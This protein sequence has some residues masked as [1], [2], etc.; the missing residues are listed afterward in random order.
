MNFPRDAK[1]LKLG[2]RKTETKERSPG[3]DFGSVNPRM[4]AGN[5]TSMSASKRTPGMRAAQMAAPV[6]AIGLFG[7]GVISMQAQA[8]GSTGPNAAQTTASAAQSVAGGQSQL[9]NASGSNGAT[10]SQDS[11]RGSVIEGKSTGTLMDLTLDDAIQRG[12]RTNLGVILQS[13]AVK[14]AN[15]ARLEQLQA[16]LPTVSGQASI[17]VEQLNL[18]A[19][20]LKIPGFKPIIGPFQVVDFR[21]YLTQNV[22]NLN[23]LQTYI[24]AKHNFASAKLTAEGCARSGGA[25][26]R[27]CLPSLC[28]RCGAHRGGEG[29]AGDLEGDA[30]SG[31][32]G[33]RGRYESPA[34]CAARAGGLSERAAEPDLDDEPAGEG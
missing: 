7:A 20:G 11:F 1:H 6:L 25:D 19:F 16:L 28:R 24:S 34:R 31:G 14:N 32:C 18:A 33:P 23:A 10:S 26:G 12:L 15:G 4:G 13:S 27:Q 2:M 17:E 30:R 9:Y 29:G 22:V 5:I 3:S 8:P 21:A